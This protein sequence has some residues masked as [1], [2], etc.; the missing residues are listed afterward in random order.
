MYSQGSLG[1]AYQATRELRQMDRV[2]QLARSDAA[3]LA[4]CVTGVVGTLII[5]GILQV[6]MS[7]P[8]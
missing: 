2:R 7:R 1:R 3:K 4:W 5:Y 8:W 6:R